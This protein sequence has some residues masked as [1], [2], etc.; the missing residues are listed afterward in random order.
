MIVTYTTT[1]VPAE[2]TSR[3]YVH[4]V[5]DFNPH[6]AHLRATGDAIYEQTVEGFGSN[7]QEAMA[8][9]VST[10]QKMGVSGV[11]RKAR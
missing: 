9:V 1:T 5:T 7:A 2:Q 11:L 8:V 4:I 3:G 10:L 6:D